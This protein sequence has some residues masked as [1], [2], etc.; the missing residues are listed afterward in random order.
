MSEKSEAMKEIEK[1]VEQEIQREERAKQAATKTL[2]QLLEEQKKPKKLFIPKL[3]FNIEYYEMTLKDLAE[4]MA[5]PQDDKMKLTV[6]ALLRTWGKADK[7]VTKEGIES[8]GITVGMA[9]LDAMGLS[10]RQ[11]PLGTQISKP[12]EPQQKTQSDA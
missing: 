10:V 1:R 11:I 12:S 9:I 4:F 2:A 6:E 5:A 8:L 3:G 7:T